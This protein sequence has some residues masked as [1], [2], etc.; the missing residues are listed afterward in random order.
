LRRNR[1]V[2][3]ALGNFFGRDAVT[4]Q[5][6]CRHGHTGGVGQYLSGTAAGT[7]LTD[8][9][10]AE[11]RALANGLRRTPLA[12]VVSSPLTRATQTADP[13]AAGRDLIVRIDPAFTEFEVGRWT[14]RTFADLNGDSEWQRFNAVRSLVRPPDGELMVEVQQRAV[15]ALLKLREEFTSGAVAVIS[16]GDVIRA[17]LLYY[18]GMPIDLFDRIEV[19]PASTSVV[20]LDRNAAHVRQVNGNTA[21]GEW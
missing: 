15:T 21:L 9:G 11:V 19:A 4:N 16:H 2:R 14:G 17:M 3:C 13:I 6:K 20:T 10:H 18:L 1:R 12:A 7:P 5:N 8:R